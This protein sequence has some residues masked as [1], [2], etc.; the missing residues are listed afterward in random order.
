MAG[1]GVWF[2]G[3][4]E[5]M[6]SGTGVGGE[7]LEYRIEEPIG[8]GGMGVVYLAHDLRLKRK[9]A[10]K[11]MAP[12]LARDDRYRARFERESELAMSVE[13]PN[14]VPIHD[15]GE[16]EGRLY[17]AMRCVD[18]TDLR[19]LLR[20][21]GAL[22]PARAL[23]IVS[24]VANALDAAHERGLV[25]RDVKP[26]NVLLD[27]NEHVYL[28]DFGLTRR[29]S[30]QAELRGDLVS[31]GTPAYL[32]PEQ[33]DGG[34]V[35]GRADVYSLGCLL[36]ECVTGEPPFPTGSR[37]AVAWAHLEQEPPLTTER[38]GALPTAIDPV[39]AKAMAKRPEDRY[40]TC[41]ELVAAATAAL[42][43]RRPAGRHRRVLVAAALAAAAVT[44][45]AI[46]VFG[47]GESPAADLAVRANT[48][49]RI[50]P[51]N[52][53]IDDV[54]DVGRQ[55]NDVAVGG[56]SVWAYNAGDETVSEIDPRSDELRR[57]TRLN[58]SA[59]DLS[60]ENGPLLAADAGGAWL[61]GFD[62]VRGR[63]LLTRVYSGGRGKREYFLDMNLISVAAADG[64]VW[65]LGQRR[66]TG[67]VLRID[68]RNGRVV[69]K[70]PVPDWMFGSE[71][72][73]LAVGGGF[74][75]ITN[76]SGGMVYRL[77]FRTGAAGHAK[78][79][80]L[81]TRPA[82]GF[83]RLWLCSWDG[84]R[85]GMV[86]VDPRTLRDEFAREALPAE[87]GHFAV[88]YGSLWRHDVPS[89]TL[90]RF[91][92]QNGDPAGLVPVLRKGGPLAVTSIATGAGRVWLSVSF[93]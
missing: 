41:G 37:L 86:R 57:T 75:W 73:G 3:H 7:F 89:G 93:A 74:V 1:R 77:D 19:A 60:L 39:I 40:P 15:A 8:Q 12:E 2:N 38:N 46:A 28:A 78:F 34:E 32:A 63:F 65:V 43:I 24:Q 44:A 59:S 50:D 82:F 61:V 56:G 27:P 71:G 10:L 4:G 26:S 20:R 85:A 11:L 87:E 42:G 91:R 22:A 79:G 47:R 49:V 30:E 13:H 6:G 62:V 70:R 14:V 80:S 23:A 31:L 36:Y 16:A 68:P 53:T 17:L 69:G 66:G 21:E 90:M 64:A 54:V 58:T 25:H 83:G 55:P 45:V 5:F 67:L 84:R 76:A 52:N 81:V 51:T 48:V 35:D 18:G 92:P 88:G 72:Q 29:L 33:I 9:V